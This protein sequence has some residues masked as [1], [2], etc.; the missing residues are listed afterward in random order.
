MKWIEILRT[1]EHLQTFLKISV[2]RRDDRSEL[3][4]N[5]L[6][7]VFSRRL[8]LLAKRPIIARTVTKLKAPWNWSADIC[9][10]AAE[11]VLDITLLPI[12]KNGWR[13]WSVVSCTLSFDFRLLAL[14]TN[15][16]ATKR[17]T[18]TTKTPT[19]IKISRCLLRVPSARDNLSVFG[20]SYVLSISASVFVTT[21]RRFVLINVTFSFELF[22]EI[23]RQWRIQVYSRGARRL[24]VVNPIF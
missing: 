19:G 11:Y 18:T 5:R 10:W 13:T 9:I 2:L 22:A 6:I 24:R 16:T 7:V 8:W 17:I 4:E 1:G 14:Y 20:T 21:V 12:R 23:K 15:A 3:A